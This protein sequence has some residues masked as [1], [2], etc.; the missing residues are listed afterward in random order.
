MRPV[1][2]PD[3]VI[4][5]AGQALQA[6]GRRITAFAIRQRVGGGD[7]VRIR[8][9][10]ADYLARC[11]K[12]AAEIVKETLP[13]EFAAA[14]EE[15]NTGFLEQWRHLATR[16]Y[17]L[18]RDSAEAR[19]REALQTARTVQE[20]AEAEMAD[21][22]QN[23]LAQDTRIA[24]LTAQY[25]ATQQRLQTLLQEQEERTQQLAT[26][27]LRWQ[28]AQTEVA[29]LREHLNQ[30]QAAT[31]AATGKAAAETERRQQ[32]EQELQAVQA[33]RLAL[34]TALETERNQREQ[35]E[36]R[37]G[38]VQAD[39]EQAQAEVTKVTRTLEQATVEQQRL[40]VQTAELRA[41]VEGLEARLQSAEAARQQAEQQAASLTRVL[42]QLAAGKRGKQT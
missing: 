9:V 19:V 17:Q 8:T 6:E 29:D 35:A 4:I 11:N 25:E 30:A 10:W 31:A 34:T 37:A 26:L 27:D 42:D 2:Y 20:Q 32:A 7:P 16:L 39:L 1:E 33:Q 36:Y 14:V 28:Q 41:R 40:A 13:A 24:E 15:L 22:Q 38:R 3:E 18:A 21:A 12:Q 5:A 23:A